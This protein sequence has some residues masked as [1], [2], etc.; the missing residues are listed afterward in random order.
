MGHG[1]ILT[2]AKLEEIGRALYG[3]N[4][5]SV[6]A[7]RLRRSRMTIFRWRDSPRAL[8]KSVKRELA[9]LIEEQML[10]LS[11]YANDIREEMQDS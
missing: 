3:D 7:N 10:A 9:E 8:G 4:W 2:G 5:P 6:L 11:D 1:V